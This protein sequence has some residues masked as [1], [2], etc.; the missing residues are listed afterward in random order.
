MTSMILCS[1]MRHL[2]HTIHTHVVCT[3]RQT[4]VSV[5]ICGNVRVINYS[6]PPARCRSFALALADANYGI[7]RTSGGRHG[8]SNTNCTKK[9]IQTNQH[10]YKLMHS[11]E[12]VAVHPVCEC[13]CFWLRLHSCMKC[14]INEEINART[15]QGV[16]S[17]SECLRDHLMPSHFHQTHKPMAHP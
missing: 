13:V 11:C 17:V 4:C 7:C 10:Q 2:A 9:N 14:I 5:C 1:R 3:R 6:E 12:S 15:A 16:R 8:K